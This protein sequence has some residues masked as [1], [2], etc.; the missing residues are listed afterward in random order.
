MVIKASRF[1]LGNDQEGEQRRGVETAER[2]LFNQILLGAAIGSQLAMITLAFLGL[3]G[4]DMVVS[5]PVNSFQWGLL[6]GTVLG[7][8][9]GALN[10]RGSG[11]TT[12]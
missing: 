3:A 10:A 9:V 5:S 6:C 7:S 2:A 12:T 1:D 4:M 11:R 8:V